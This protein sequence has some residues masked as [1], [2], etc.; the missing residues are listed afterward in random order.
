MALGDGKNSAV[1]FCSKVQVIKKT[2]KR[3][4]STFLHREKIKGAFILRRKKMKTT[5][6][7]INSN[8]P[9]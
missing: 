5:M 3:I 2:T 1:W 4:A 6:Q 7:K 8:Q 9:T